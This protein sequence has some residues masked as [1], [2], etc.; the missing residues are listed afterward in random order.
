MPHFH[1]ELTTEE[2]KTLQLLLE[3]RVCSLRDHE[4]GDIEM[5]VLTKVTL[6]QLNA[7]ADE[8]E[9]MT[10]YEQNVVTEANHGPFRS[11]EEIPF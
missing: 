4:P 10:E 1:L 6:A 8:D 2:I 7:A 11:D 5:A 9:G 3:D